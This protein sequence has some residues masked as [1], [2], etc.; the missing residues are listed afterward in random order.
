MISGIAVAG[1]SAINP[2]LYLRNFDHVVFDEFHTIDDRSFGLAC[3]L[4]RLAVEERQGRVSLLSAT[5]VDV[6]KVLE[7]AGVGS[8]DIETISEEIVDGHP[9]RT[10]TDSMATSR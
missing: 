5:P 2:F 9:P 4:S 1:A 10:S 3:L 7:R 8:D 6:T